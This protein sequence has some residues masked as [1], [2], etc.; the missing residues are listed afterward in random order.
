MICLKGKSRQEV[1]WKGGRALG[2]KTTHPSFLSLNDQHWGSLIQQVN[3]ILFICI[4][5]ILV[6]KLRPPD[7]GKN[8][9]SPYS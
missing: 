9:S 5:R 3:F 1:L 2:E 6:Q 4:I 8:D 7:I